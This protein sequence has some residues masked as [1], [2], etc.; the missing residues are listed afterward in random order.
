MGGRFHKARRICLRLLSAN[1][2]DV[3]LLAMKSRLDAESKLISF[4]EAIAQVNELISKHPENERLL[5]S[6]AILEW[7][8]GN[9]D[10][11]VDQLRSLAALHPDDPHI[12]EALAGVLPI[13]IENYEE[14]WKNYQ[15]ALRSGSLSSP[16]FMSRAFV[17]G[18]RVDPEHADSAFVGASSLDRAAA[19]THAWGLRALL[20]T[21]NVL[22]LAAVALR[23]YGDQVP[24]VVV[25]SIVTAWAFWAIFSSARACCAK[26]RDVSTGLLVMWWFA[27]LAAPHFRSSAV[28]VGIWSGVGIL[29]VTLFDAPRREESISR[30]G[31]RMLVILVSVVVLVAAAVNS[32][33]GIY[34]R[35][36]TFSISLKGDVNSLAL[37]PSGKYAYV[38]GVNQGTISEVNVA[39]RSVSKIQVR[40]YA[41][42]TDVAVSPNGKEL[43]VTSNGSNSA[44]WRRTV[45]VLNEADHQIM[46]TINVGSSS[47]FVAFSPN[48]RIA[49]VGANDSSYRSD[50][51]L[52]SIDVATRRV[53]SST[54]IGAGAQMIEVNPNGKYVYVA[55]DSTSGTEGDTPSE[56]QIIDTTKDRVIAT[57]GPKDSQACGLAL[58][59][60][61]SF[62]Y[63][64][65]C[66]YDGTTVNSIPAME[67]I[68]TSTNSIS[69]SI[70][71]PGGSR[72]I[73]VSPNGQLVYS[74]L[75]TSNGLEVI[76]TSTNSIVGTIPVPKGSPLA[77]LN[78]LS[79]NS[80]GGHIYA[81][82]L[83]FFSNAQFISIALDSRS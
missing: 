10:T 30:T 28:S 75:D 20:I 51:A 34:E 81:A 31:L 46:G 69:S 27:F 71:I 50:K 22:A 57:L 6:A 38:V 24:A 16:S 73:V 41:D 21:L 29:V 23:L 5:V 74:A 12:H 62:L 72:G 49:Y 40:A 60:K 35:A 82:T 64:S 66:S 44:G 37:S 9:R 79:I 7:R 15:V 77:S 18:K 13:K 56:I 43:Y 63:A 25:L 54:S 2:T 42:V 58:N 26:C 55:S 33:A 4:D 17:V 59:P 47:T 3:G 14:A 19:R 53:V 80:S 70:P 36:A 48:G 68:N 45:Y 1:P 8:S 32:H 39:T 78:L 67:V 76:N 83:G 65:F 11:G 61:G 52:L